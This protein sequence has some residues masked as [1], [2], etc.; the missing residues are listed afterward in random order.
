[1]FTFQKF[2][3]VLRASLI[4]FVSCIA[5]SACTENATSNAS[6]TITT[7]YDQTAP[8][9]TEHMQDPA[10]LVF[11]KTRGWRHN[12]GIAGA[13]H[14]F[15]ELSQDKGFGLFTT[16]NGAVFNPKDLSRFK[17][18]VFN[19]MTGDT[20][21]ESQRDAF[22]SWLNAGGAWI[23]L[24]G[25]GDSS[26]TSWPWYDQKLI[27]PEFIGHPAAPQFQDARLVTLNTDHP[28]MAGIPKEW[29]ITDEWYSFDSVPQDFGL[30][31]LMGLDESSYS[32]KNTVYGDVSDLRMGPNPEDHPVL[33]A[34]TIGS[35]RIVYSALGHSHE[36]YD[37]KI[38]RDILTNAF[39][40]VQETKPSK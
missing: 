29:N 13:D 25:S 5:L 16:E 19:N 32:P 34:S 7:Q 30:T 37:N 24:H 33:W 39:D 35:G 21:S 23:G 40:W 11:S 38:Y 10:I 14:F 15:S 27:G 6:N 3:S 12:E 28:I 9:I 36:T 2:E 20:L 31:P 22:K 8:E 17:V 26:H 4:G 1:M 18:I